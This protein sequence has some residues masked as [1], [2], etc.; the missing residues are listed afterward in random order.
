MKKTKRATKAKEI[1]LT[2]AEKGM[3]LDLK[4]SDLKAVLGDH[5]EVACLNPNVVPGTGGTIMI[6]ANEPC[7]TEPHNHD[8][9]PRDKLF[10]KVLIIKPNIQ[11]KV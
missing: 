7:P 3:P 4:L 8:K 9:S 2:K 5:L 1:T 6:P 10:Q 11:K